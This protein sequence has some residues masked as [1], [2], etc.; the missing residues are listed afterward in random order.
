MT[1]L[2]EGTFRF[3]YVYPPNASQKDVYA[4][5]E[6]LVLAF[7]EGYNASLLVYGQTGAGKTYTIGCDGFVQSCDDEAGLLPRAFFEVF[8]TLDRLCQDH[9][10]AGRTLETQVHRGVRTGVYR[11]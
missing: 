11:L 6:P 1:T 4:C 9:R 2:Q 10:R 5:T 8:S 3:D 7:L